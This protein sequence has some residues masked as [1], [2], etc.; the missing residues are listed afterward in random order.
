MNYII[1]S[2]YIS[3]YK[4]MGKAER[5]FLEWTLLYKSPK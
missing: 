1:T 3:T 4:N 2:E 5:K